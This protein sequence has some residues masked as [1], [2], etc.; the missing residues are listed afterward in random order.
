MGTPLTPGE[1]ALSMTGTRKK[2][3]VDRMAISGGEST[4]NRRWLVEYIRELISIEEIEQM[5][6][7]LKTI[8]P[9]IQVTVLDCRPE[10]RNLKINRPSYAEM[11]RIHGI[12]KDIGFKT[13]VCQTIF[14]HIGP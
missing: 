11:K 6:E 3:S 4:L 12:L 10:F 5:G 1:A 9:R 14:G 13:V 8:R 7:K 2:T